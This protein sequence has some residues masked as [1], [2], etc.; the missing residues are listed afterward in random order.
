[1][2]L[3]QSLHNRSSSLR[4][5]PAILGIFMALVIAW[6]S[7]IQA[8][9]LEVF[10]FSGKVNEQRFK[11]LIVE[12]RCLKCQNQSLADS[13]AELAHDLRREIFGLMESGQSDQEITDFL[14]AR[15]GDFVLY[16]PPVKRETWILWY[17]P[18]A[19]LLV[20]LMVL[21][22]TVRK[23]KQQP[24]PTFTEQ[25]QQQLKKLL[26]DDHRDGDKPA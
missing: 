1:M 25:E 8:A 16:S 13:D 5:M 21:A 14:V 7:P 2:T 15:Y 26:G 24:E 4:H 11:L 18:F 10:D 3:C 12:L 20:G 23:R 6:A 17:G 22:F 9:G 19:L